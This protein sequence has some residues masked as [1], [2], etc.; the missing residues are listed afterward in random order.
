MIVTKLIFDGSREV[1]VTARSKKELFANIYTEIK[2]QNSECSVQNE[3]ISREYNK[4]CAEHTLT[5]EIP[6]RIV[7]WHQA[8]CGFAVPYSK[9]YRKM[10]K[11]IIK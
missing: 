8:R 2:K 9:A 6:K 1:V 7:N 11:T 5:P 3:I 4:W 10:N